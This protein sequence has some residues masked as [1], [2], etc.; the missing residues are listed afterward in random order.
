MPDK[1]LRYRDT[2]TSFEESKGDIDVAIGDDRDSAIFQEQIKYRFNKYYSNEFSLSSRLLIEKLFDGEIGERTLS[3]RDGK[4]KSEFTKVKN[5]YYDLI[6][7]KEHLTT[8]FDKPKNG[9]LEYSFKMKGCE[10]YHQP[11]LTD[12]REQYEAEHGKDIEVTET[13]VLDAKGNV[14]AER[15]PEYVN[16]WAI[17]NNQGKGN[18]IIYPD[19][20]VKYE[21]GKLL[22]I[23]RYKAILPDGKE[24]W[25]KS[26]FDKSN[27]IVDIPDELLRDES[28][29]V[30]GLRIDPTFGYT[31][32]GSTTG[33]T[34]NARCHVTA[35]QTYTATTGDRII[36][37]SAY[38]STTEASSSAQLAAYSI[39]SGTPANRLAAAES[40][41]VPSTA[42]W[43]H[44]GTL[45]QDLTNSTV[46]G[47]A[48]G[49]WGT[50]V[51]YYFDSVTN[52]ISRQTSGTLS[53]TWTHLGYSSNCDS[54]Y[55]TYENTGGGSTFKPKST[56]IN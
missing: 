4:I 24:V 9:C 27:L 35:A 3:E 36:K 2:T 30:K 45:S 54:Q 19:R 37:Y 1:Q 48:I 16:S 38:L 42:A 13:Q 33:S 18:N 43:C 11:P 52:S 51:Y 31:T 6:D 47:V 39:S 7:G 46:Y 49:G 26:R 41:T 10:A 22:H 53:A 8:L 25:L 40:V 15:P 55:A 17:Y 28:L 12:E 50:G 34:G 21:T 56:F 44:T 23:K 20:V 32:A 5:E 14:I 29:F